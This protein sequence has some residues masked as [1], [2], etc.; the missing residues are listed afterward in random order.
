MAIFSKK[1]ASALNE[2]RG[3]IGGS[4]GRTVVKQGAHAR[5]G[6]SVQ[7]KRVGNHHVRR[8]IVSLP[9]NP[10]PSP[11]AKT[12]ART[13]APP[14]FPTPPGPPARRPPPERRRSPRGR[15]EEHTSELQ[16]RPHLVWRLLLE[17]KKKVPPHRIPRWTL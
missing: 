2:V 10:P 12:T 5:H 9:Q 1:L 16:S 6:N 13:A 15:S 14:R 7:P 4:T 8:S 11:P 3:G 17:K